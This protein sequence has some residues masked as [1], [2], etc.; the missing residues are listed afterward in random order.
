MPEN[1]ISF[2]GI[3]KTKS[4]KKLITKSRRLAVDSVE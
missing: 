1:V 2:E 4:L 3:E